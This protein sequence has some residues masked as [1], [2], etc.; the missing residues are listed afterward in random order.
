[1]YVKNITKRFGDKLVLDGF[2]ADFPDGKASFVV[3]QSGCGKS[4]LLNIIMGLLPADSGETDLRFSDKISAVFQEDRLC[5]K[6][7][8][9]A[10]VRLV[11]PKRVSDEEIIISLSEVGLAR[12]DSLRPVSELSGGMKRRAAIVR[13]VTAD[14]RIVIMDEPFKG[15]DPASKSRTIEYVMKNLGGRTFIAVTHDISEANAM[16]GK[17]FEIHGKTID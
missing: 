8:A 15:L 11:C 10:N 9:A 6:L 4:T 16:N 17:I 14:S 2:S 13:A 12:E 5:E 1:M 7:S 3:G